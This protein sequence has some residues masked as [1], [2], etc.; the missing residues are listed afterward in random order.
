MQP[1]LFDGWLR[2]RR[3]KINLIALQQNVIG[4]D[5]HGQIG[6]RLQR[7]NQQTLLLGRQPCHHDKGHATV[8]G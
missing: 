5:K 2:T 4:S 1:T 7:R 8:S 6:A 3:Y